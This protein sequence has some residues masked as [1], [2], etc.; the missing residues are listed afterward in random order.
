MSSR[1]GRTLSPVW[2]RDASGL[3]VPDETYPVHTH[4]PEALEAVGNLEDVL[5]ATEVLL[6]EAREIHRAATVTYT[7]LAERHEELLRF[8]ARRRREQDKAPQYPWG[9]T[10]DEAVA[11]VRALSRALH[12]ATQEG[13]DDAHPSPVHGEGLVQPD[14]PGDR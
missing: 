1:N 10:T 4:S 13:T 6:A 9:I 14:R 8:Q 2:Y 3:R 11:G 12:G 7:V 5:D